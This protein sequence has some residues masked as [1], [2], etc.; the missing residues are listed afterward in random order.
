MFNL[1]FINNYELGI[2]NHELRIKNN[3]LANAYQLR[4]AIKELNKNAY[5]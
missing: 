5:Q 1:F 3:Q 2:N 4:E